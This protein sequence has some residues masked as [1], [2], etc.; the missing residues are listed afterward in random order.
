MRFNPWIEDLHY[1]GG[2]D[3]YATLLERFR[4]LLHVLASCAADEDT[5]RQAAEQVEDLTK[6]LEQS[7]TR[8]GEGYSGNR[9]DLPGR[10]HPHL[11]PAV[12]TRWATNEITATLVFGPGHVGGN[13]AVH[14]GILPLLFDE[15]MGRLAN[16]NRESRCRTAYLRTDYR[17]VVL[18][19]VR[20][21]LQATVDRED[22]RKRYLSARVAGPDG[23]VVGEAEGLF[24]V[25][26]EGAQ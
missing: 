22:G 10:G 6:M 1:S 16:T 12:F 11:V 13:G 2:G 17:A 19:D 14:G 25:L 26:R 24:V 15:V 20:Y 21:E 9:Y 4:D 3:A 8:P 7:R 5:M 18:V 23:T